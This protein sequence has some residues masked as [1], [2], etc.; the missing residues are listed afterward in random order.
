VQTLNS[1]LDPRVILRDLDIEVK[2]IPDVTTCP[3]CRAN[4][5]YVGQDPNGGGWYTCTNCRWVGDSPQL[6][7]RVRAIPIKG[8]PGLLE[9]AG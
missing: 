9:G 6:I 3:A 2:R 5:F 8:R 1:F 4:E 7:S